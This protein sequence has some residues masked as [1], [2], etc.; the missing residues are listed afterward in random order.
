MHK[1]LNRIYYCNAENFDNVAKASL[2]LLTAERREKVMRLAK[3]KDKA[4][5]ALTG[6]MLRNILGE[7]E[8]KYGEHGKP[9]FEHGEKFSVSHSGKYAVLAVSENEIG[10]DIEDRLFFSDHIAERFFKADEREY[11]RGSLE[12]S[13]C[14]WTL[15]EA[16]LKLTG[17]GLSYPPSKFSVLPFD[18]EHEIDGV[19]MRFFTA[20]IENAPLSAAYIGEDGFKITEL[21]PKDILK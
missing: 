5:S 11:C 7:A 15:K 9:Y 3:P 4:L 20:K 17:S 2:P 21:F 12:K 14:I 13:L 1:N 18:G 16:A 19:R 8:L 6:L 10:V